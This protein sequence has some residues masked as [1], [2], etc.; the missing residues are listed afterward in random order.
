MSRVCRRS[1]LMLLLRLR[2]LLSAQLIFRSAK[3]SYVSFYSPKM[4]ITEP[5]NVSVI[6]VIK[7]LFNYGDFAAKN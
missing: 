6:Y 5:L 2:E 7:A 4:A 3:Y 1:Q